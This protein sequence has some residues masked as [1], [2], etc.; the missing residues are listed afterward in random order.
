MAEVGLTDVHPE[1]IKLLGRLQYRTSYGQNVL[2]H[3]VESSHIASALAAEIGIDPDDRQAR[4]VPARHRQGGH[5]RGRGIVRDHRRR[6]RA[7]AEGGP[8]GRPLHRVASRGGRAANRPRRPRADRGLDQRGPSRRP[9]GIPGDLHQAARTPRGDPHG[10]RRRRE[11]LRDAGRSRGAPRREP[12]RP[13]SRSRWRVP[14]GGGSTVETGGT[15]G[16]GS[17]RS[18]SILPFTSGRPLT[19]TSPRYESMRVARS[20]GARMWNSSGVSSMNVVV[21]LPER[22]VVVVDQVEEERDVRLHAADAELAQRAVCTLRR[23]PPACC[24]QVVTLTSSESKYGV[25]TDPPK[26]LPPSRR[27]AKPPGRSVGGNPP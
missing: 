9:T 22:N 17:L 4:G 12:F 2:K 20:R 6:D 5:P 18:G 13:S 21:A 8:G 23:L 10:A 19:M 11:S 27:T 14:A 26:P 7:A 24:P 3:L 1:L 25:I 15:T 16:R